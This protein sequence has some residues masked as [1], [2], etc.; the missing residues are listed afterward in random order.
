ME[1]KFSTTLGIFGNQGDRWCSSYKTDKSVEEL[2]EAAGKVKDLDGVELFGTW[3][4]NENNID[5]IK[6]LADKYNFGISTLIV[7]LF[8]NPKYGMGSLASFDPKI[9][10]DAI[11]DIKKYMD[12]APKLKC[13]ILDIWLGQDGYDYLFQ[14][15]YIKAWDF[16]M[17]SF[18]ECAD[19]NKKVKLSIEYK[20]REPRNHSYVSTVG[21]ALTMIEKIGRDNLGITMDVGHGFFA[22]ENVAESIA[23][24]K[25]F[26][27][28]LF[29]MHF[30]DNYGFADDDLIVGSSHF[31][32]YLEI[33]YWLKR[34]GYNGWY[35]LD[36]FPYRD[37]GIGACRESI[38]M[39]KSMMKIVD[40]ID[41]KEF[42]KIVSECDA[43]KSMAFLRKIIFQ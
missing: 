10:K 43:V 20:I 41:D 29:H 15:D 14:V 18:R 42:D 11:E 27:D 36:Q 1:A 28:R 37:E 38:A 16:L 2:F 33:L 7:D 30:N 21:K 12:I 22:Y 35:S 9:R 24:C 40:R 4:I 6:K 32:D 19:H 26:G 23:M 34:T 5:L 13:N 8:V 17:D 25:L 31:Q 3:H 39:L